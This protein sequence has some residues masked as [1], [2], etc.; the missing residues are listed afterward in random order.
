MSK[1][2]HLQAIQTFPAD[3]KE[4]W[5]FFSRPDNLKDITP[6]SLG[7]KVHSKPLQQNMYKG[8]IIEYTVKPLLGIP[9]YWMTEIT[10][11]DEHKFFVDEQRFGPYSFWHHEHHFKHID[12]G[13]E[14]TDLVHYKIPYWILGDV[15]NTLLVRNQLKKIFSFR[16]E[17][18]TKKFGKWPGEQMNIRLW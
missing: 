5:N 18:A 16:Y 6:P 3:I 10:E 7:F 17:Y 4:V 12:D 9:L 2:Y 11:I 1:V 13:I 15:A 14:M 8:Q